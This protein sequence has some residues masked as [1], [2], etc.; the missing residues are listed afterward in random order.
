MHRA[1]EIEIC[2]PDF[3]DASRA[4]A[5]IGTSRVN[6]RATMFHKPSERGRTALQAFPASYEER[7]LL[8]MRNANYF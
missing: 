8:M 7:D 2:A 1:S 3:T 4:C 5:S 6:F